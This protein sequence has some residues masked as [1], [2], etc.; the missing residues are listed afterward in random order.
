MGI[1]PT[2]LAWEARVMAIIRRPQSRRLYRGFEGLGRG[3]VLAAGIVTGMALSWRGGVARTPRD[4]PRLCE[5]SA[6]HSS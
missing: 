5:N 1:E 3:G 4:R 6:E 2:S